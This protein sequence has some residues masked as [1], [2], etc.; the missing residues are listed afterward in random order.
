MDTGTL[1]KVARVAQEHGGREAADALL[2]AL[3]TRWDE[4]Q[5]EVLGEVLLKL[6]P[7]KG[8]A[9]VAK[10]LAHRHCD[11]RMAAVT[12]LAKS[13]RA[14]AIDL[15]IKALANDESSVRN[16]AVH[17]LGELKS[18]RAANALARVLESEQEEL[19]VRVT[20]AQALRKL[21]D[22]RGRSGLANRV[23]SE[24][25]AQARERKES[26]KSID[27][28]GF[29]PCSTCGGKGKIRYADHWQKCPECQGPT[30]Y[31]GMRS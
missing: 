31:K 6:S 1:R 17:A 7:I 22:A 30:D 24:D 10:G 18:A 11:I 9:A 4:Y 8:L 29:G 23:I 3:A 21:G 12:A 2:A 19:W 16:R 13:G 26:L 25:D 28:P 27:M 20:A 14:E 5:F 15:L